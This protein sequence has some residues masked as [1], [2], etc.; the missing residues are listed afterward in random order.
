M[1]RLAFYVFSDDKGLASWYIANT[2]SGGVGVNECMLQASLHSLPFGGTGNSGM[3]HY[4]GVEGFNTFSKMRGVFYQGP[5][6][7]LDTFM[8]PYQ[9][10]ATKMLNFM[11][12]MKS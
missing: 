12:W 5:I 11:L 4:H 6:R 10:L 2:I 7:A 8:P 1:R 3:G 9:G